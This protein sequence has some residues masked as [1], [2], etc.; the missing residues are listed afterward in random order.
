M[1][2]SSSMN[3]HRIR[4]RYCSGFGAGFGPNCTESGA[5]GVIISFFLVSLVTSQCYGDQ[6]HEYDPG[7]DTA[8]RSRS[9]IPPAGHDSGGGSA[10]LHVGEVVRR[11]PLVQIRQCRL[12]RKS[13]GREGR[14]CECNGGLWG[15]RSSQNRFATRPALGSRCLPSI[16]HITVNTPLMRRRKRR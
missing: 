6:S 15:M 11:V 2:V 14:G 16:A 12:P 4:C 5:D 8:L 3:L 9:G 13:Q 7:E 10:S 1:G